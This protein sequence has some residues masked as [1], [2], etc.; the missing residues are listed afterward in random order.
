MQ[1]V[2]SFFELLLC[3][4]RSECICV[5]VPGVFSEAYTFE[6]VL[7]CSFPPASTSAWPHFITFDHFEAKARPVA[8]NTTRMQ[9]DGRPHIEDDAM[10]FS[11]C[12]MIS[13]KVE[14]WS[15][16]EETSVWLIRFPRH[17][18]YHAFSQ[19]LR[20]HHITT[21]PRRPLR[22]IRFTRLVPVW[23]TGFGHRC[24]SEAWHFLAESFA[25][26]KGVRWL[27]SQLLGNVEPLK[28]PCKSQ[29]AFA[30]HEVFLAI[31]RAPRNPA[32]DSLELCCHHARKSR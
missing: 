19:R 26:E 13:M 22:Q 4:L 1:I 12:T 31:G 14:V 10:S 7:E 30:C 21:M 8:V 6:R 11:H 23:M 2:K 9:L 5:S 27:W 25:N 17:S 18:C 32:N 29:M 16:W 28:H 24:G 3:C 20:H 15:H